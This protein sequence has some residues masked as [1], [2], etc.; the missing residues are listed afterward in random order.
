[1]GL[2]VKTKMKA[3]RKL[4]VVMCCKFVAR[5]F[6]AATGAEV[7]LWT[8]SGILKKKSLVKYLLQQGSD[9]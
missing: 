2:L 6:P 7:R 9:V 8:R 4:T 3:Y 1:M 5:R